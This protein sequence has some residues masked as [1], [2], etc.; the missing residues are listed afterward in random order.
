MNDFIQ[1]KL[2]DGI[3]FNVIKESRFKTGRISA[4][5][6]LP[7]NEET[8]S[9]NAILPFLLSKSCQEFP[10]F[11]SLNKHLNDL[12]GASIYAE[13]SK[14]GETQVL[15]LSASFLDDRYSLNKESIS[16]KVTELLCKMIFEPLFDNGKFIQEN[17][18]QEKRQLIELIESEYND[19]RI[20]A[21][22]RCEQLMCQDEKFGINR[23]GTKSQVEALTPDDIYKAWDQ[24][25]KRAKIELTLLGNSNEN[26]ALDVFKRAFGK[27]KRENVFSCNTEIIKEAKHI[28]E[29]RE[30]MD[31]AQ[32]KLVMGFRT[33]AALQDHLV[34]PMRVAVALFG[35][36]PHS[37]L[38]LNVREKFSLCYYC[39]ARYDRNKGIMLVQS[40]VEKENIQ[41]AKLEILNQLGDVQKGKFTDNDVDAIKKS[42]SNN[43]RTV[44]DYLSSLENFYISQTFDSER[45]T[46]LEFVKRINAVT[47]DQI[48]KAA[49]LITLD[50]VYI[51]VG[52]KG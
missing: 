23:F 28:K 46:P 19:K 39:A 21:K 30:E 15:G 16:A 9:A 4:T 42:L 26:L 48:V 7:L 50:T 3:N 34:M 33:G 38:F 18:E 25:L 5:M 6:F 29:N 10:D 14:L 52:E 43:Y 31:L 51:L 20:F 17:V 36:T 49:N 24:I 37:K 27:I 11:T 2:C 47:K 45:V 22:N 44:G 40:G 1:H 8:V 41:K 12:Y 35:S 13:V 32:S